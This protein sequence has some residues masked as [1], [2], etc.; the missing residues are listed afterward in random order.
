MQ[1]DLYPT[2][3]V[4]EVTRFIKSLFDNEADLQ[5][6]CVEGE[7]SNLTVAKSGHVYFTIKDEDSQL[8][9]I[10][11][12]SA[13]SGAIQQFPFE[14]GD[15][16]VVRGS[17]SVY[18]PYGKYQF[19]VREISAAGKGE[20]YRQFL[21]LKE[22]LKKEGLF[23]EEHK[24]A[25]PAFPLTI[26]LVT[27]PTGAVLHDILR[28]LRKKFPA[29]KVLLAPAQMQGKEAA[30]DMMEKLDWLDNLPEPD[31]IILARGGGS[32]EDLWPFNEEPL[33]RKIF[34]MK[35]PVVSAVGHETDFSISDFVADLRAPTPTAA[36]E[37]VVPD[38]RELIEWLTSTGKS[39]GN[40]SFNLIN[41]KQMQLDD[42]AKEIKTA[43]K[44]RIE[45]KRSELRYYHSRLGKG[46][47]DVKLKNLKQEMSTR[48]N[49]LMNDRKYQLMLYKLNQTELLKKQL[50]T[51][52]NTNIRQV[53]E[54]LAVG[55]KRVEVE[56]EKLKAFDTGETLKRGYSLTMHQGK[57]VKS[58]KD[59]KEGDHIT[60]QFLDGKV[61]STIEKNKK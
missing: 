4:G 35:K 33:A 46:N 13:R 47:L 61:D 41:L 39:I 51:Q 23:D 49:Q 1:Q 18:V 59:L 40:Q 52:Q 24:K 27:S 22:N 43:L 7:I 14:R 3:S 50:K 57:A 38:R 44:S 55:R 8:S 12:R 25:L 9:C 30:E 5:N 34:D 19:Y 32:L 48:L 56:R 36:A 31:V 37:L 53:S 60:T 54:K 45:Q 17:F 20:L 11:F 15:Q 42:H 2:Y 26:G 58:V 29:V 16:V 6:I 21:L 28:T 10:Q